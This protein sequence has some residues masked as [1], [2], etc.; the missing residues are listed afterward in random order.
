MYTTTDGG[1]SWKRTRFGLGVRDV[2]CASPSFCVAIG[3][4][5]IGGSDPK[6]QSYITTRPADGPAAWAVFP[7]GAQ[8]QSVS[9]PSTRLCVE[10]GG[11]YVASLMI[12]PAAAG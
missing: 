11:A 4:V 9:C 1:T 8:L 7:A 10:A 5:G 12:P 3:I 2:S 6:P